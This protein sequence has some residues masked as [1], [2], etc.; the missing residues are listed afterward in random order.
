MSVR[1]IISLILRPHK[2]SKFEVSFM[3]PTLNSLWL[4]GKIT[5]GLNYFCRRPPTSELKHSQIS[6]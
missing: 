2:L 5:N 4:F 1:P 6:L 3:I